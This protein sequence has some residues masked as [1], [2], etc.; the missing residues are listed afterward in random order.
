MRLQSLQVEGFKSLRKTGTL[1][2]SAINVLVGANNSGKSSVLRALQ[3]LQQGASF[4]SEMIS[5]G[6]SAAEIS[7]EF[8]GGRAGDI[9]GMESF[10]RAEWKMLLNP[11]GTRS[12]TIKTGN[13]TVRNGNDKIFP[14]Q[15]P[16]HYIVPFFSQ[17]RALGFHEQFN[18]QQAMTISPSL[19][20]LSS[21]L[22]RILNPDF[23]AAQEFRET[24]QSVLGFLITAIPSPNGARPGRLV[25]GGQT[26]PIEQCGDGVPNIVGFIASL[27]MAE[28]K[29]FLIEELENDLHPTALKALLDLV[30]KR[31][32]NNQFVLTTHSNVVLRHLGSAANSAIFRVSQ[33]A[34]AFPPETS[35]Q[36]VSNSAEDRL[37]LLQELGYELSDFD[38]WSGWIFLEE[39]SAE[40]IIRDYLV[41]W[42][43]PRLS[44]VRTL[45]AVGISQVEPIFEDFNRLVRFTHL[46]PAYRNRAWVL[47]D[48]DEVGCRVVDS[49]R[50]RYK[51][52]LWDADR[53]QAFP[54]SS[55]EAFYPACFD[56]K[57]KHVLSLSDGAGRRQAKKDLLDEVRSW[58]DGDPSTGRSELEKSAAPVIAILRE[59]EARVSA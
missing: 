4:S 50:A 19:E 52:P 11:N 10:D 7:C 28:G 55:F 21:R 41:P 51:P 22:I 57:V 29:L 32:E 30:I 49:L 56:S 18:L 26:I 53:F 34:G 35:I 25:Q 45:A 47:V 12:G 40:R 20:N 24:C 14:N 15:D 33:T 36:R 1:G 58:L 39:S 8:R 9:R 17:R 59:I 23:P 38:L 5:L 13:T 31:S 27:L 16:N 46:E 3:F 6:M 48:G 2:F 42:F 44:R 37:L 54:A 43:A